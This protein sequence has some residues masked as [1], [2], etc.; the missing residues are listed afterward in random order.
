MSEEILTVSTSEALTLARCRRLYFYG[1]KMGRRPARQGHEQVWGA[2]LHRGLEDLF[3]DLAA[4]QHL[5]FA[6]DVPKAVQSAQERALTPGHDSEGRPY[7]PPADPYAR[8]A[9]S[10]IL[11]A[12]AEYWWTDA[13]TY[14][15]VAVEL[16]FKLPVR[17]ARGRLVK[18]KACGECWGFGLVPAGTGEDGKEWRRTCPTCEGDGKVRP[19]REGRID[20]VVRAQAPRCSSC[21]RPAA[22]YGADAGDGPAHH[23]PG[24]CDHVG[25]GCSPVSRPVWLVEHKSTSWEPS[26]ERYYAG[27]EVDL[28][29]ALYFD[30]ARE[31][32]LSPA[33]VMYDVIRRPAYDE[34][35]P[36][37]ALK[38][39]GTARAAR[40]VECLMCAGSGNHW[41]ADGSAVIGPC[42][43]CQGACRIPVPVSYSNPRF[44]E[45]PAAYEERIYRLATGE[46]TRHHWFGR[47]ELPISEGQIRAAREI[48]HSA[49][50][51][52]R[53]RE[54][55]GHWP[56]VGD[57]YACAA[58]KRVCP[59][60]DVCGGRV[61]VGSQ[62]FERLY[63]LKIK[64][65]DGV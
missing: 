48:M 40:T 58:A 27:I 29:T 7:E 17:T 49:V 21:D 46:E 22:C 43:T 19:R 5:G 23:C 28:Q 32:G 18:G 44:G 56:M 9:L 14:E 45:S 26:D 13:S 37:P 11:R 8:A 24:H 33:G 34:P 38:K 25:G 42:P 20:L 35:K 65:E 64:R 4:C 1:Y 15:V 53:W 30:A 12:Y 57:R 2:A 39:D 50:D 54:R 60:L 61:E 62:E 63:P 6:F 41:T 47:R 16:P 59:W 3:A 31:L 10:A 36:A 51:E 52:I 55:T